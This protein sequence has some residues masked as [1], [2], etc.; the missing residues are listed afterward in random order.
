MNTSDEKSKVE[1]LEY[2]YLNALDNV[3]KNEIEYI[4]DRFASRFDIYDYWKDVFHTEKKRITDLGTGAER[5]FWK[6]ISKEFKDWHPVPLYL[7][8]N[9]F[10][11]TEEAYINI[12]I[13]T[14]YIDNIRD[15]GGLVEV[16]DAQTS[17][18]MKKKFETIGSFQPKL[19]PYYEI[20]KGN[21]VVRKYALTYFIQ[22]IYEK[23]EI[24]VQNKLDPRP[25]AIVFVSLPNGLLHDI[26]GDDVVRYPK[27]YRYKMKIKERPANY[28][29]HYSE[30]PCYKL[31]RDVP[32]VP[33]NFRVR[34]YYNSS[35][36]NYPRQISFSKGKSQMVVI[37]PEFIL[38]FGIE[39]CYK[40]R[41]VYSCNSCNENCYLMYF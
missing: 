1:R 30:C 33:C 21:Q 5:V 6:V 41:N 35:Y 23:P 40:L 15:L 32:D 18:P 7:G 13:K 8:S 4:T 11:E 36:N 10:F 19:R 37:N 17:Y 31:L 20:Q 22:I 34:L 2:D 29:F 14:A 16:G 3:I 26:Y 38:K 9:L 12:D 39:E 27:S 24:I 25:I 28:R